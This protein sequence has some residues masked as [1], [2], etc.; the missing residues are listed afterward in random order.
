MCA[1]FYVVVYKDRVRSRPDVCPRHGVGG[2]RQH[3]AFSVRRVAAQNAAQN[4]G[5]R[6]ASKQEKN[7]I[8]MTRKH[9]CTMDWQ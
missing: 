4:A 1:T 7:V 6:A 8:E 9:E 5:S 2:R 3:S